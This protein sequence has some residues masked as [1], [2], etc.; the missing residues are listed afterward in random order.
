[1]EWSYDEKGLTVKCD[2]DEQSV[3]VEERNENPDKFASDNTM[4]EVFE[5]LIANSELDW[6]DPEEIGAL[7]SAPLLCIR[8]E[9]EQATH[10]WKFDPYCLRSPQDDLADSGKVYFMGGE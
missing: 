3:L 7:T 6:I 9:K 1:M 5:D 4:Y 2:E 10:V 8:D